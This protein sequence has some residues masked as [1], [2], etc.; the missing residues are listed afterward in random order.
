[1]NTKKTFHQ[2][3]ANTGFNALLCESSRKKG[4]GLL[5]GLLYMIIDE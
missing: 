5:T 4:K 1:M 3:I 2:W